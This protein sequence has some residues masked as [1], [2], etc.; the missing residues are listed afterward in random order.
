MI[1]DKSV[2]MDGN[3]DRQVPTNAF[4]WNKVTVQEEM[5]D[6]K[7]LSLFFLKNCVEVIHGQ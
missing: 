5:N 4:K 7:I 3:S 1:K 6:G 2:L